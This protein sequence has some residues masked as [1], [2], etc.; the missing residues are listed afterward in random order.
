MNAK[1]PAASP[2]RDVRGALRLLLEAVRLVWRANPRLCV[3]ALAVQVV[4]GLGV[5]AQLLLAQRLLE[6]LTTLDPARVALRPLVPSIVL[7]VSIT[8][9]L[10]IATFAESAFMRLLAENA[11]RHVNQQ[12]MAVSSAV[13]LESFEKPAF[14][15]HLQR[16]M[17]NG[18]SSPIDIASG[19]THLIAASLG[20]F[21]IIGALAAIQPVLVPMVLLGYA[22]V[23]IASTRN[24]LAL[25]TFDFGHTA[26]DRARAYLQQVLTKRET[27]KEV[28]AFS[29]F[30]FLSERW[31]RL[32]AERMA[33]IRALVNQQ[34]WR[35]SLA[36]VVTSLL[37]AGTFGVLIVLWLRGNLG[38]AGGAT[39]AIALQQL[40]ARLQVISQQANSLYESGLFLESYTS[41]LQLGAPAASRPATSQPAP[42]GFQRLSVRDV[43][44]AYPGAERAALQGVSVEFK[45]G[46]IIALVGENGSGKT[47]LAKLLCG[48]YPP[49]SGTIWWDDVDIQT[50]DPADLRRAIAVIFQEFAHYQL[51]VWDNLA[52][53]DPARADDRAGIEAAARAAGAHPFLAALPQGYD[54]MLSPQF[55]GGAD[56]SLGQWQR[57][58]IARAFFRDAPFLVLDEPTAALDAKAESELFAS[59][60]TLCA[61]RTVLLISHRF[62]SVRSADRIYVLHEGRIVEAGS[63]AQLMSKRGRYAEMFTLQA[64]SYVDRPE[65]E[66]EA[67]A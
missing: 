48:L 33:G 34:L 62:S 51:S 43:S 19:L 29:L 45:A 32:Y 16:A 40:G 65:H 64:S 57:V 15:D 37:L 44:Y 3:A 67:S 39:A 38:L 11:V 35:S 20:V 58:A 50:C 26:N 61:Q 31:A 25:Y 23:W 53:G 14:F 6:A 52:V 30:G 28:R 60:R 17:K 2:G 12:I 4:A 21:G 22:P 42:R 63:H 13:D 36:S 7:L 9:G 56:L 46:E 47:T 10:G 41:F 66:A 8:I 27:A 18:V 24:S 5:T 59:L 55:E 54:T 1:A 49:K